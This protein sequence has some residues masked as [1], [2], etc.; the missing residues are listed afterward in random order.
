VYFVT[1]NAHNRERILTG[2]FPA[3]WNALEV[4][5]KR[6]S[7]DLIAWVV[8]PDHV[9]MIID[10]RNSD[11]SNLIRRIKL[12]FSYRYRSKLGLYSTAVWQ[13][14]F[15]DHIIRNQDDLNHHIDY[16]HYNPVKHGLTNSP[17]DWKFSS[18]TDYVSTGYYA[19]DWGVKEQL[20]FEGDFGECE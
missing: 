6:Q 4:A 1:T 16:I 8:M 2:M 3:F 19:P 13:S 10:P 12:G 17:F 11:L 20:T 9:H 7:F 15:W 14:R 5:K 18:L